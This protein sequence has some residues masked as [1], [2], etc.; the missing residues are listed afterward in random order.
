MSHQVDPVRDLNNYLQGHS[1]GNITTLLSWETTQQGPQHQVTHYATAKC[2]WLWE[3]PIQGIWKTGYAEFCKWD[4]KFTVL[5]QN[6]AQFCKIS[7]HL[8]KLV[9]VS[10]FN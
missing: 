7:S 2:N 4:D 6:F 1:S 3:R 9:S 10:E 8:Q 5:V